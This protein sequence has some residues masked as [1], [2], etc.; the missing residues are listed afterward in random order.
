MMR[1]DAINKMPTKWKYYRLDGGRP[2]QKWL[3]GLGILAVVFGT[4]NM[5]FDGLSWQVGVV[6]G[7]FSALRD[8]DFQMKEMVLPMLWPS[9]L[10]LSTL[11]YLAHLTHPVSDLQLFKLEEAQL[12]KKLGRIKAGDAS[13]QYGTNVL[14]P[15]ASIPNTK[16]KKHT[17]VG[18]KA[19]AQG[20]ALF[21]G[22][23]GLGKGL[24]ATEILA[25]WPHAALVIDPKRELYERTA[26][27][28]QKVLGETW[29]IPNCGISLQTLYDCNSDLDLQT[30][31]S[32]LV[33]TKNV[34][35]D[36]SFFYSA[37]RY[38]FDACVSYANEKGYDPVQTILEMQN[39][40]MEDV[41]KTLKEANPE[42][43]SQFL[44]GSTVTNIEKNRTAQ[45]VWITMQNALRSYR[46]FIPLLCPTGEPGIDYVGP[47]WVD[48]KE[49][50]YLTWPM[51][52]LVASGTVAGAIIHGL[53]RN[54][55]R[56]VNPNDV[57]KGSV[58]P[59]LVIV[60]ELGAVQ[61]RDLDVLLS[62]V[63]GYGIHVVI[64]VQN[65][66]QL[67]ELYGQNKA[68]TAMGNC[69]YQVFYRCHDN[70]TSHYIAEMYGDDAK[71]SISYG[72]SGDTETLRRHRRENKSQNRSLQ[73]LRSIGAEWR[74]NMD[75]DIF[76]Q[77][78]GK[79]RLVA[80]RCNP[81][82]SGVSDMLEMYA[83]VDLEPSYQPIEIVWK[84][85]GKKGLK[86]NA[87]VG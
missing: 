11:A 54:R 77:L 26:G 53:I 29:E 14:I 72:Q 6:L 4:I 31:H 69:A 40:K 41:M 46:S 19:G 74:S 9:V 17:K 36:T 68:I 64:Y 37:S 59:L 86:V 44:T 60:D 76:V 42:A 13:K 80:K 25:A 73:R 51:E 18:I 52:T 63:R 32:Y 57:A 48:K 67:Y 87:I 3:F 61:I 47:N 49:T 10:T 20:H 5:L 35:G 58:A 22:P 1:D 34:E 71:L 28:R 24:S 8:V 81:F 7:P 82:E 39:G 2:M 70:V 12:N 43:I 23:T 21:V 75:E 85:S 27:F 38:I 56:Q 79:H 45:S 62:T 78:D 84:K 15:I 16:K 33:N 50:I 66:S 55:Q 30:L 65:L 83:R